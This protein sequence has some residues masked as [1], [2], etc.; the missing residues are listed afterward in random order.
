[1]DSVLGVLKQA[2]RTRQSA[3]K[4]AKSEIFILPRA[5]EC[6]AWAAARFA[7]IDA[8]RE[9]GDYPAADA[10]RAELLDAGYTVKTTAA[11]T[12]AEAPLA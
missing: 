5:E 4:I 8:A 10:A 12:T 2:G 11:G 3:S 7:A 1:M 9:A 6:E